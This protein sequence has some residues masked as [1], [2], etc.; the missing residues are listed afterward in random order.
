MSKYRGPRLRVVRR[1]GALD[2]FTTKHPKS[3]RRP[4]QHGAKQRK[5]TQFF[6]RLIEKQ[7]LRFY[8]GILEKQLVRYIKNARS[9]KGSTSRVLIQ[10]LEI[11]LDTVVYRLGWAATIPSARQI[12]N[13]GHILVNRKRVTVPSFSCFPSCILKVRNSRSR[14]RVE[15]YIRRCTRDIPSFLSLDFD[16]LLGIVVQHVKYSEVP[17][18]VNEFFIVEYYSNRL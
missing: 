2:A 9:S 7:K 16:N 12:V 5:L 8:Y 6:Y 3:Q 14:R 1:L 13:H 18:D 17:L 10:Q 15:E 4:G 11:R